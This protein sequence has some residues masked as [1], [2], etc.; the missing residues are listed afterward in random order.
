MVD[1]RQNGSVGDSGCISA[2]IPHCLIRKERYEMTDTAKQIAKE[3]GN[4]IVNK[5]ILNHF[6]DRCKDFAQ[7]L[8]KYW[9]ECRSAQYER[10]SYFLAIKKFAWLRK[11]T[12]RPE[13][14]YKKTFIEFIKKQRETFIKD[15][16]CNEKPWKIGEPYPKYFQPDEY[17]KW[18]ETGD[19]KWELHK[20]VWKKAED[21]GQTGDKA[22]GW[23]PPLQTEEKN[24]NDNPW[25]FLGLGKRRKEY[26]DVCR[27][28]DPDWDLASMYFFIALCHDY[29][30]E[31]PAILDPEISTICPEMHEFRSINFEEED[32]SDLDEDLQKAMNYVKADFPLTGQLEKTRNSG[33]DKKGNDEPAK[34]DTENL[35]SHVLKARSLYDYAISKFPGAEDMTHD[36]IYNKLTLDPKITHEMLPDNSKTFATY[37]RRS[38]LKRYRKRQKPNTTRSIRAIK[39]L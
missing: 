9:I 11:K 30:D 34:G 19:W 39:E 3:V 28:L 29:F 36:E 22:E 15:I 31:E 21:Y 26:S 27:P 10:F 16:M 38:G 7:A 6:R 35:P 25:P 37:L 17:L 33:P 13:R 24:T 23:G 12:S 20:I 18:L 2:I 32:N 4:M 1:I 8:Q 14:K 5:E